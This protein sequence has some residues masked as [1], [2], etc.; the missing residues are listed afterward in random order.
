ME[1]YKSRELNSQNKKRRG[2]GLLINK[3]IIKSYPI[4]PKLNKAIEFMSAR[5]N[6]T[7]NESMM[8]CLYYGKQESRSIKKEPENEFN[9]ISTYTKSCIDSNSYVLILSDFNAKVGNEEKD[10]VNADR[11]IVLY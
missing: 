6:L 3:S 7:N 2:I 4:E 8:V 5:L 11:T 9:Q 1:H 10:I